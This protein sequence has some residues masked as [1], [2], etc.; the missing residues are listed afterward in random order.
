MEST[1]FAKRTLL[2]VVYSVG[3]HFVGGHF[4]TLEH[5]LE[6]PVG[7]ERTVALDS[8]RIS[9]PVRRYRS[10]DGAHTEYHE[11]C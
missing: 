5:R 9:R 1:V 4:D 10:D 11:H 7:S 3:W 6:Q 8:I 2:C